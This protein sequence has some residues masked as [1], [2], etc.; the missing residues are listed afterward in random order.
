MLLPTSCGIF[1]YTL[2]ASSSPLGKA[3]A[4]KDKHFVYRMGKFDCS[5]KKVTV[6]TVVTTILLVFLYDATFSTRTTGFRFIKTASLKRFFISEKPKVTINVSLSNGHRLTISLEKSFTYEVLHDICLD[7]MIHV[8]E[9]NISKYYHILFGLPRSPED[10]SSSVKSEEYE[11]MEGKLVPVGTTVN[12]LLY[13]WVLLP[14][15]KNMFCGMA[16]KVR[17]VV[18]LPETFSHAEN[19]GHFLLD[20][21]PYYYAFVQR[22]QKYLPDYLHH[23]SGNR[24]FQNESTQRDIVFLAP[25]FPLYDQMRQRNK[26]FLDGLGVTELIFHE[27]NEPTQCFKYGFTG[28]IPVSKTTH[29]EI[30]HY[31]LKYF[32]ITSDKCK[33]DGKTVVM[34][35]RKSSRIILNIDALINVTKSLGYTN[36]M[37]IYL[38]NLSLQKQMQII[39][40][41]DVLLGIQGSG[42]VWYKYLPLGATYIE[43]GYEDWIN[44]FFTDRASDRLDLQLYN[45]Q[46][47]GIPTENAYKRKAKEWFNYQG[48][49]T[50]ELKEKVLVKSHELSKICHTQTIWMISN[51]ECDPQLLKNI[52]LDKAKH[53][54]APFL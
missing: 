54:K 20:L 41:A 39:H 4:E 42:M 37:V 25:R 23:A 21:L 8:Q 45:M 52:L 51:C 47:R 46:C 10:C 34:I 17:D 29:T 5:L 48:N 35:Q 24:T 32:H 11:K 31:Y 3:F 36:V 30:L 22:S 50:E 28:K 43:V 16:P 2:N 15:V 44:H 14:P 18:Y 33:K 53:A 38:E 26:D 27:G 9:G 6:C 12:D 19:S 1:I 7:K 40:C 49:L 13:Y